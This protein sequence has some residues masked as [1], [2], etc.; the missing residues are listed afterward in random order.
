MNSDRTHFEILPE[1]Q[2][3][4][5]N[6]K[7][8][9]ARSSLTDK[10]L[11][12]EWWK[13][14]PNSCS[15]R[16]TPLVSAMPP[17][18]IHSEARIADFLEL[19]PG[20]LSE[21]FKKSGLFCTK[22]G[23]LTVAADLTTQIASFA[24]EYC[25]VVAQGTVGQARE[26]GFSRITIEDT[27][28]S[29]EE[30]ESLEPQKRCDI[31]LDRIKVDSENSKERLRQAIATAHREGLDSIA[32]RNWPIDRTRRALGNSKNCHACSLP[33][34]SKPFMEAQLAVKIWTSDYKNTP[35]LEKLAKPLEVLFP[36]NQTLWT[37]LGIEKIASDTSFGQLSLGEQHLL[38]VS[39]CIQRQH[40]YQA[41]IS[42]ISFGLS[43]AQELNLIKTLKQIA[44]PSVK[45]TVGSSRSTIGQKQQIVTKLPSELTPGS[46][47]VLHHEDSSAQGIEILRKRLAQACPPDYPIF[48]CL[49]EVA[50]DSP[51]SMVATAANCF[52][53]LRQLY[54]KLPE[55]RIEGLTAKDFGLSPLGLRCPFCGG[56]G[57]G[58]LHCNESRF[59]KQIQRVKFNRISLPRLLQLPVCEAS[60]VMRHI[61][62]VYTVLKNLELIGLEAATLGTPLSRLNCSELF[63]LKIERLLS[64]GKAK[65]TFLIISAFNTLTDKQ[66]TYIMTRINDLRKNGAIFVL[67]SVE[68][69]CP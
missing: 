12:G 59:Q 9:T 53:G 24:G 50:S 7:K 26:L 20:N 32:L 19:T 60:Q 3:S 69:P 15:H 36:E 2:I 43:S 34:P 17:Y 35:I 28:S 8:A 25:C 6:T 66:F 61:P 45:I 62:T 54:A 38:A 42:P 30:S 68:Q 4:R 49:P 33:Y 1:N 56:R 31:I 40:K 13:Y 18:N 23:T 39:R 14:P 16:S 41:I 22:C 27:V 67:T 21:F 51:Y 47:H 29:L 52:T 44:G 5:Y 63:A 10:A 46:M 65:S 55:A 57:E 11:G 58:C 48:D 37:N 64:R